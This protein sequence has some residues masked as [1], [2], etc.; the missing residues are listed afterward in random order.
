MR[1]LVLAVSAF[2][3]SCPEGAGPTPV[4]LSECADKHGEHECFE[5]LVH[6]RE[7]PR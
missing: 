7:I 5:A 3:A 2:L 4:Q 6:G 1:A